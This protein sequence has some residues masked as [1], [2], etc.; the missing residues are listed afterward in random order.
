[1][2]AED[3]RDAQ[4][5]TEARA[6]QAAELAEFDEAYAAQNDGSQVK[7][8]YIVGVVILWVWG[9]VCTVCMQGCI[10]I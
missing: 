2:S 1:M 10:C 5:A 7:T 3:E 8:D 6:E 4:A 9:Y